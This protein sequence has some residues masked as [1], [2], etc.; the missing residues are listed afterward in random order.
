M[1]NLYYFTDFLSL[2]L[3]QSV[4]IYKKKLYSVLEEPFFHEFNFE[5]KA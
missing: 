5:S 1:L 2:K 4:I 3:F